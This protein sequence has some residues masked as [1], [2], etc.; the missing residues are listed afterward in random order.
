[1]KRFQFIN[2]LLVTILFGSCSD[3][4][5]KSSNLSAAEYALKMKEIPNAP[6]V[7]VRTPEEFDNGHLPKAKNINW[8]G[9]NFETKIGGLDK[10][11]P[12]FVYCLSGGRS[13]S[14]AKKMRGMGFREVYELDGGI[15]KWRGANLPEAGKENNL[16]G[17]SKAQ[18]NQ[19]LVSDKPILIDFYAEWCGPC[20]KMKPYFEEITKEMADKVKVI[21][22]DGDANQ[23]LMKE[24]DIDALPT[25][26]L[27]KNKKQTWRNT[28]YLSKEEI[29]AHLK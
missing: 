12:V 11:K 23:A 9:N 29:V 10:A 21:R 16:V 26:F 7:D 3:A 28:G 17:M 4:Q 18:F 15:L 25:L 14:A 6:V 22:I 1:M 27:Y 13:G 19:L 5:N 2:I 8:N 24:M 20:R